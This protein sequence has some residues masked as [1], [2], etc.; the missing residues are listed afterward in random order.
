MS[1]QCYKL[2]TPTMHGS[3][4][5]AFQELLNSR[6]D[7][8]T[9]N[10]SVDTDG[11][12]GPAS[13][14]SAR[15]VCHGLGLDPK[16]YAIGMTPAVRSRIAHPERRTPADLKRG[17]EAKEWRGALR[18]TA[19]TGEGGAAA[20]EWARKH[21]GVTEHPA[22][23]NRGPE[24]D[25]WNKAV[26][27]P[28]GPMAYWCGA[29][30][31]AA[32]HAAGQPN[33]HFMAY[34]PNIEAHARQGLGG[35]KWI[36]RLQD[37]KPGD[38]VLYTESSSTAAHVELLVSASPFVVIGGNTSAAA[39]SGSQ[40]NGGCVALHKDRNPNSPGLRFKGYARPKWH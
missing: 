25:A 39:G 30:V 13:E 8:W 21:V 36:S 40:S 26:G 5:K 32:L 10:I 19:G 23:S 28:P 16:T 38:C 2:T 27:T 1:T 7:G 3:D 17:E 6:F 18:K 37:G 31:N 4:V 9:I 20:V 33:E 15:Q 11:D 29:F 35:W 14:H 12:Y 22:G 24:V 34:C